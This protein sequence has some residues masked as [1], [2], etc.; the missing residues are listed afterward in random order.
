MF[1]VFHGEDAFSRGE[2]IARLRARMGDP[3][4][5]ALNTSILDGRTL[6]WEDLC[7]NCDSVPF[8]FERRL[9]IVHGLLE[10]LTRRGQSAADA[11]MLDRLVAYLP[12]LPDSTRLV[13]VE[14]K[15]LPA[16]HPVV[17]LARSH[18]SGHERSFAVPTGGD[19]T[20]W[21]RERVR[22][23]GGEIDASGAKALCAFVGDDLYQ[24]HHEIEKLLAYTDCRRAIGEDDIRAITPQARQANIF[25]LVDALGQRNGPQAIRVYHDLLVTDEHPLGILGM[26]VRQ[27]R[28]LIQVKELAPHTPTAQ[29]IARV[30]GQ[31]PYSIKKILAQSHNYSMEQLRVVYQRLLETD[32]AIKTGELEATLA[33]DTLIAALSRVA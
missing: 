24:L 12:D 27:F 13:L 3:D 23:G 15:Q 21:V 7:A 32:L 31:S 6:T 2:E 8:L 9:V 33:L 19:L 30:L 11:D 28:L 16:N 29:A 25:N 18:D 5:A 22:Q 26:I 17:A 10:R 14:Q 1:Y 4:M 20:R